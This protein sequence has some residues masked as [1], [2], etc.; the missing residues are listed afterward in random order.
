MHHRHAV[1]GL[2]RQQGI[3]ACRHGVRGGAAVQEPVDRPV[4]G[5]INKRH[6]AGVNLVVNA[7]VHFADEKQVFV[8][9][10]A[11]RIVVGDLVCR[12]IITGRPH[13]Q[14]AHEAHLDLQFGIRPAVISVGAGL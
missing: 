11:A 14:R 10:G 5:G 7:G 3:I 4:G 13:D 1:V 9:I 8:I 6:I 12:G 2:V